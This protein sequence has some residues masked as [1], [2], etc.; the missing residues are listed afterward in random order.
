MFCKYYFSIYYVIFLHLSVDLISAERGFIITCKSFPLSLYAKR[1]KCFF[2]DNEN[3]YEPPFNAKCALYLKEGGFSRA[4]KWPPQCV[5]FV[6]PDS[7]LRSLRFN[8]LSRSVSGKGG[9]LV[10]S[11]RITESIPSRL[12]FPLLFA[13]KAAL[14]PFNSRRI[15]SRIASIRLAL[16]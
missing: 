10:H 4:I 13:L 15:D 9:K 2:E 7:T 1:E 11:L 3:I 5:Q 8:P 12:S 6:H 14:S 16:G